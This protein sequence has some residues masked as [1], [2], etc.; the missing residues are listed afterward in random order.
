MDTGRYRSPLL[1]AWPR[2]VDVSPYLIAKLKH[3]SFKL[4][5]YEN[6]KK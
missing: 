4:Y 3:V 6:E 2:I 1:E 5:D